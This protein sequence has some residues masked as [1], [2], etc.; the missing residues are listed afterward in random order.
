MGGPASRWGQVMPR[1]YPLSC[2][3]PADFPPHLP[4]E[5]STARRL[6]AIAK[7]PQVSDRAHVHVLPRMLYELTKLSD[8]QFEAGVGL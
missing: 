8:E 2:L 6:M 7:H 4:F 3:A 1:S 5:V